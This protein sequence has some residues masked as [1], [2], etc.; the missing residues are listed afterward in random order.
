MNK[1]CVFCKIVNG[2]IPCEKIWEDEKIISFLD[3]N[4]YAIGHILIIPKKHSRWLWDME[5]EDYFYLMS[6][7]K[8]LAEVLRKAFNT[9][10]VEEAVAGIGV[11]HTHVHLIPRKENDGL[12]EIP[13]K[14][15][16]PKPSQEQMK[17][18]AE[19]IKS[20]LK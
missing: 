6:K 2:E 19:K 17:E 8:F 5:E 4:P 10:W 16:E 14:P 12:E 9:E 20:F 3:V 15:L 1:D 18:I 7:T 13:I 11:P